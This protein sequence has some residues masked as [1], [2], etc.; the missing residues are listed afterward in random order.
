MTTAASRLV[1]GAR[2]VVAAFTRR[3]NLT[4][5]VAI[6]SDMLGVFFTSVSK[7]AMSLIV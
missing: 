4:V 7:R 6:T 2:F 1:V 5:V 3:A